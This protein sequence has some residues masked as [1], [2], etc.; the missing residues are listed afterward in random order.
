MCAAKKR[1]QTLWKLPL[2]EPDKG[3]EQKEGR[4]PNP[5][6]RARRDVRGTPLQLAGA[7]PY[8]MTSAFLG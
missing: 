8:L 1:Q 4:P 3:G 5:L 2:L 7:L 6:E